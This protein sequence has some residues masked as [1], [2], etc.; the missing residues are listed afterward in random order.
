MSITSEP[1]TVVADDLPYTYAVTAT[2]GPEPQLSLASGPPGM[3][4]DQDGVIHWV[5]GPPG[6]YD[7]TVLASNG[8]E[9]DVTQ[10]FSLSVVDTA[11][12]DVVEIFGQIDIDDVDAIFADRETPAT[13]PDDPRDADGDGQITVLDGRVCEQRCTYSKCATTAP[14]SLGGGGGG[15]CGFS[16]VELLAVFAFL[17]VARR[18]R[19]RAKHGEY[20]R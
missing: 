20:V 13:G 2:G 15:L 14:L 12:C 8:L 7:V 4:M 18:C 19:A 11:V 6:V 16:G 3:E 1:L 9:P 10:T 5:A 17:G